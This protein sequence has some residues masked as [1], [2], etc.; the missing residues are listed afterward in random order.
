VAGSR[1][2]YSPHWHYENEPETWA[3][4][5]LISSDHFSRHEPGVFAPLR[6]TLLTHGDHY[7]HLAD[8]K[9]YLDRISGWLNSMRTATVGPGRPS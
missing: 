2:W 9:G 6:D 5:D 4:L 8:L 7:M 1:G 3:A